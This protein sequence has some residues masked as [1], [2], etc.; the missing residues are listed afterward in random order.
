MNAPSVQKHVVDGNWLPNSPE[1]QAYVDCRVNLFGN[2]VLKVSVE[3]ISKTYIDGANIEGEATDGYVLMGIRMTQAWQVAGASGEAWLQSCNLGNVRYR[4]GMFI[5]ASYTTGCLIF[6][7]LRGHHE[8]I[9]YYCCDCHVHLWR[10]FAALCTV[11]ESIAE[12]ADRTG[13]HSL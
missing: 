2:L 1:H 9:F 8:A 4:P 11:A 10:S 12:K 7:S 6:H 3:G 5:H 13:N